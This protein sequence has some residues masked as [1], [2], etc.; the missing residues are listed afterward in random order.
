LAAISA[1][2]GSEPRAEASP[3][4]PTVTSLGPN[5]G[6][7]AGGTTVSIEGT[8]LGRTSE[9]EFG[10]LSATNL[11]VSSST[12]VTATAPAEAPGTVDVSVITPT[13]T[14]A[15]TNADL[16][17]YVDL[18]PGSVDITPELSDL[19]CE[20]DRDVATWV[21]PK[22]HKKIVGFQVVVGQ[23]TDSLRR[24]RPSCSGP[25]PTASRSSR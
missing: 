22:G 9:V 11:V 16:F 1:V 3:G 15:V 5:F 12:T 14:N 19:S 2:A 25:T 7:T 17:T 20:G 13:G 10:G 24:F 23:F 21:P 18:A 6:S 8:G 4:P